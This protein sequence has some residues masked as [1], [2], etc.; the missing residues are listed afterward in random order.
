MGLDSFKKDSTGEYTG[1]RPSKSTKDISE[2]WLRDQVSNGLSDREISEKT[3]YSRKTITNLRNKYGIEPS[4]SKAS[5]IEETITLTKFQ[6]DVIVGDLLSDGSLTVNGQGVRY[7]TGDVN[8][9]YLKYIKNSL[10]EE[11]FTD[12]SINTNKDD[13]NYLTT[14]NADIFSS[15]R[16][17]WYPDGEKRL[18]SNYKLNSTH[19][20]HWYIGDGNLRDDRGSPRIHV[21]WEE[22][23]KLDKIVDMLEENIGNGVSVQSDGDGSSIYI[24][25][26]LS[27]SFFRF[28]GKCPVECY[29]YKW[30]DVWSQA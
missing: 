19:I 20:L 18:P 10:P 12:N 29:N 5:P 25:S 26:A 1:G 8:V 11:L 23:N 9:E 7:Q 22:E 4:R 16:D 30:I 14:R 2:Q 17:V 3:D 21:T 28:I 15:M 27:D 24:S 6:K 13:F